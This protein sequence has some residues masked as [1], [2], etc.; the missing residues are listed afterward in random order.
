MVSSR[1]NVFWA[2]GNMFTSNIKYDGGKN[3]IGDDCIYYAF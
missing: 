2:V 3:F 1:N